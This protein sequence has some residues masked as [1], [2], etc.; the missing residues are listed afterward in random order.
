MA[1]RLAVGALCVLVSVTLLVVLWPS[2][3]SGVNDARTYGAFSLLP[4]AIGL[5]LLWDAFRRRRRT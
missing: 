3:H 4:M 1:W 2:F 5:S